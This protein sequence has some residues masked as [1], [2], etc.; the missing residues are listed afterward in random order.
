MLRASPRMRYM[1]FR[2][3]CLGLS[4]KT[5]GTAFFIVCLAT[6]A[7]WLP[8]FSPLPWSQDIQQDIYTCYEAGAKGTPIQ[9]ATL[10]LNCLNADNAN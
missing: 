7:P 10:E 4:K 6:R 2:D 8:T 1:N 5:F 9:V 3:T